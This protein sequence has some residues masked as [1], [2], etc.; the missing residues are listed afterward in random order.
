MSSES[1][2][3]GEANGTPAPRRSLPARAWNRA[4]WET[5]RTILGTHPHNTVF[6]FNYLNV[7]HVVRFL[8]AFCRSLPPGQ[9]EVADIGGGSSPYH[10]LFAPKA[11]RYV[12]VDFPS[13]FAA[14]DPRPIERRHGTAENVPLPDGSVDVVVC[15][16][17]LEHVQDAGRSVAEAFRVLRPGGWYVGSVP[18][19]SPVHLEPYDFRRFTDLGLTQ[20]LTGGGFADVRVEG[21]T[22]AFGAAALLLA[23]DWVLTRRRDGVP[24]QVSL[25]RAIL[26]SP[27]VGGMNLGA[28]VLDALV[29]DAGRSPANLC[30]TA[31]KPGAEGPAP[32][33]DRQGN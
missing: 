15:N 7:R 24:Q 1:V 33:Q 4:V 27:L 29:G 22:G 6:S 2:S 23:M 26:L 19:V 14:P 3:P 13:A 28:L 17:V 5:S 25:V 12:A 16:Q 18:H 31:R 9:Y 32:Q 30:W 10:S 20:I 8:T 21:N 11:A